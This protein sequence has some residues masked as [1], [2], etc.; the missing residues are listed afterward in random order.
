MKVVRPITINDTTLT[1]TSVAETLTEYN[2]GTSYAVGNQVKRD[3]TH[4][5]YESLV[6]SNTGNTPEDSP[7]EWLDLGPTNPWA[8]FDGSNTTQTTASTEIEVVIEP[9][10]RVNSVALIGIDAASVTIVAM[11]GLTEVYNQTYDLTSSDGVIDWYSYFYEEIIRDTDL[12]VTDIPSYAGLEITITITGAT[13]ACGT[14]VVGQSVGL[15]TSL[16]SPKVGMQDYSRAEEDD[17]GNVQLVQRAYAKTGQFN[18]WC[19]N[20]RIGYVG[21]LLADLRATPVVW[22]VTDETGAAFNPLT[23]IYGWYRDWN[24]EIP[25]KDRSLCSLDIKGLT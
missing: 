4:H 17:F 1:S 7:E 9:G 8:M 23:T 2:A 22:I 11:L 12:T 14:C 25:Y 19:D 16:Y 24:I 15:G 3:A 21:R 18:V 5:A 13:V 6:G 20:S 10:T